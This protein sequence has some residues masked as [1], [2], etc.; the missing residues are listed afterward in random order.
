[1]GHFPYKMNFRIYTK[2][3]PAEVHDIL[4]GETAAWGMGHVPLGEGI[5][6]GEVG[7]SYF[8]IEPRPSWFHKYYSMAVAEG[9]IK[10]EGGETVVDVKM[11]LPWQVY[12]SFFATILLAIAF[13]NMEGPF[14]SDLYKIV[15]PVMG[16]GE[17]IGWAYGRYRFHFDAKRARQDMEILLGESVD[18]D[19]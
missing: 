11:R 18:I 12:F 6:V 1:M 8:K 14:P 13:L 16:F 19:G 2:K 5:F 4:K 15:I 3:T 10:A 17:F 9:S 7:T